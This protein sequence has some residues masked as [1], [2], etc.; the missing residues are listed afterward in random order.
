MSLM[1]LPPLMYI[2]SKGNAFAIRCTHVLHNVLSGLK[3]RF[4]GMG[5]TKREVFSES[6]ILAQSA[7]FDLV[8]SRSGSRMKSREE[9]VALIGVR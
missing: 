8:L 7:L 6:S 3:T 9:V 1:P 5:H 4:H 2:H